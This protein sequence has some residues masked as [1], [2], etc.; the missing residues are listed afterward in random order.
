MPG[1]PVTGHLFDR[2][3]MGRKIL[4]VGGGGMIGRAICSAHLDYGDDVYVIDTRV[5]PYVDYS[6]ML[7]TDLTEDVNR[8]G[9]TQVLKGMKFDIIS[10]QA[11]YVGVGWS[12]VKISQHINNNVGHSA[13]LLNAIIDSGEFPKKLMLAGS[14]GPYGEGMRK[15]PDC[16]NIFDVPR[17]RTELDI[18]CS[19][20]GT[21]SVAVPNSESTPMHPQSMYAVSKMAQEYMY[22]VFCQ[23]YGIPGVSL[24]YFSVYGL[25]SNPNNPYTGVLSVIANKIINAEDIELNEDGSQLRDLIRDTECARA[26]L[27]A[28]NTDLPDMF[29]SFN[30]ATGKAYSLREIA[31]D[32]IRCMKCEGIEPKLRFN[33]KMRK[34]D[35]KDCRGITI[36]TAKALGFN[37]PST[38]KQDIVTYC[39]FVMANIY[40]FTNKDTCKEADNELNKYKI[41]K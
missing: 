28:T 38:V 24:R 30:I 11:A 5:N 29:S 34:G 32:M 33:L 21:E 13:D 10:D 9:L 20:C 40:K 4:V 1:I 3:Y 8:E 41:I 6:T 19:Q 27:L 31:E 7:G 35:V 25:R 36:R 39:N 2:R 18:K 12:Q 15:C 17:G 16:G 37:S 23:T 26:H 22:R 14:M